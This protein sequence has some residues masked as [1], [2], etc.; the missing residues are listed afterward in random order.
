[1]HSKLEQLVNMLQVLTA[2]QSFLHNYCIPDDGPIRPKHVEV[3]GFYN[4]IL[5][6]IQLC[7]FFWF[8]L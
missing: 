6:L 4:I 8:N 2:L 7:A 1:V 5:N 3:S